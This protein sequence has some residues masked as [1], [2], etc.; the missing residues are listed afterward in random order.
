MGRLEDR[1]PHE[2][3]LHQVELEIVNV[4]DHSS[5]AQD[6]LVELP[7]VPSGRGEVPVAPPIGLLLVLIGPVHLHTPRQSLPPH[8]PTVEEKLLSFPLALTEE[9]YPDLTCSPLTQLS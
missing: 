5:P 1:A 6:H 2:A 8:R 3:S 7:D 4:V 9:N